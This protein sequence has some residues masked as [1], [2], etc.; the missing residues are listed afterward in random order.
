MGCCSMILQEKIIYQVV[1]KIKDQ[2]RTG[3]F[4]DRIQCVNNCDG[5]LEHEL[6]RRN[7]LGFTVSI[8]CPKCNWEF[9]G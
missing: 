4:N 1:A 8:R 2:H 3:N 5:I 7:R 6:I 9:K